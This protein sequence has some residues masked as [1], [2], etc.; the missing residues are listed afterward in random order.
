MDRSIARQNVR[1]LRGRLFSELNLR[2]RSR[3]ERLL[4]EEENKLGADLEL[5]AEVE[6]AIANFDELI[7]LIVAPLAAAL[8]RRGQECD[9][10]DSSLLRG[11]RQSQRLHKE[12]HQSLLATFKQGRLS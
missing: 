10:R 2:T 9:A 8:E 7:V 4:L 5:I 3:V 11:L 12:Y 1:H 6:R